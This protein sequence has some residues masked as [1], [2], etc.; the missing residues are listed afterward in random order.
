MCRSK[1]KAKRATAGTAT[2]CAMCRSKAKAFYITFLDI[3]RFNEAKR[4]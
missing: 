3:R 4:N 2:H 1:A